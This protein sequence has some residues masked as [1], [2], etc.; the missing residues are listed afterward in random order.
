MQSSPGDKVQHSPWRPPHR[1]PPVAQNKELLTVLLLPVF[2]SSLQCPA[3]S[4]HFQHPLQ[5]CSPTPSPPVFLPPLH[6]PACPEVHPPLLL[7]LH[8]LSLVLH[9]SSLVCSYLLPPQPHSSAVGLT[10]SLLRCQQGC[11]QVHVWLLPILQAS[12][13]WVANAQTPLVSHLH[14]TGG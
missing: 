6:I 10:P 2:Y 4:P 8:Q 5:S 7:Y 12:L 13:H 1:L 11:S 9:H 3:V 14:L